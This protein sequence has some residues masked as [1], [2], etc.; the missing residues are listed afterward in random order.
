M[1][2]FTTL[3]LLISLAL[4]GVANAK[5]V[6]FYINDP[7]GRDVA[8]YT[9]R[10]PLETIVGTT[11]RVTGVISVDPE[12]ITKAPE[13]RI[14]VDLAS[15]NSGIALRDQHM[16]ENF[17]HTDRFPQATF[18]LTRILSSKPNKLAD[19]VPIL[20]RA[21]GVLEIHGVKRN[22]V[23]DV[24]ATYYKESEATRG[25]MPG[26]LIVIQTE[27]P[28]KL[29]QFNIERPKLVVL[30]LSDDVKISVTA[31]A[32]TKAS[33]PGTKTGATNPCNPCAAKNPCNPCAPKNP[34]NPCA[35][36]N[37]CKPANPCRPKPKNPC[38]PKHGFTKEPRAPAFVLH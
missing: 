28:I 12:N 34:C 38:N 11:N 24:N 2:R 21:E 31:V 7:T 26:D 20:I 23:V 18:T 35:P 27:F 25:K 15:L 22:V 5:P 17:L 8:S 4:P 14:A 29:S 19:S 33:P 37:P 32:S 16:R 13:V 36:K 30:K 9:S 6:N 3:L 1:K 10:A